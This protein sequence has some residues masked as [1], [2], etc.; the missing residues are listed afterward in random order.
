M[1]FATRVRTWRVARL[2][3][4]IA[5]SRKPFGIGHMYIY[6]SWLRTTVSMT[7]PPGTLCV[8]FIYTEVVSTSDCVTLD[9]RIC[10]QWIG[11]VWERK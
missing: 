4:E 7:F 1:H 2:Y 9:S 5:Q 11:K 6:T 3:S 8:W 10:E